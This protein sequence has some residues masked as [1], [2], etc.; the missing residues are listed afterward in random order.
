[1]VANVE[2]TEHNT[3]FNQIV[4]LLEASH[5]RVETTDGE[6][7]ILA[8]VN[9]RKRTVSESSIRR[10]LKLNNEE[11]I[12]TLSDNE[13]F[14]NLSLMGYNILPNQRRITRGTIQ[15]SQSK[16]PSPGADET[17]FSTRDVRYEE[18][19][20]TDTSLDAGQDRE[21]IAKTSA[22]PHEALPRVTSLSGGEGRPRLL[23]IM[24]GG[25]KDLL[26]RMLQTRGV[27]QEEDL[28]YRDKSADKGRN[29]TNEM[30]HVLGTLGAANILASGGLSVATPTTRVTRSLRGVVIVS[31]SLI[32]ANIPSI[33]KED[34]GKGKMTEP[35]Q[36]S[37]EKIARIHAEKELEMMIAK[38]DRSNKIIAKY[39]SEYEQAEAGLL[40]DEK[41]ELINELLIYQRH[42]AQIKK[43]QAQQNKPATKTERRNFY[44]SILRSN[45]GWKAKDFK[46]M[47]FEQIEE[48]L[49]P[50]WEKIQ[51]FVPMNSKL[52]SERLKRPRIQLDKE[53]FKK[54]KTT[55]A[56]GT[57]PTQEQQSEEPKELSEEE[58][59]KM[60]VLVPI[61]E[62]YIEALQ[63]TDKKAK[64]LWVELKRLYEPDFRDPLWAL[65]R[66]MQDLLSM[67]AL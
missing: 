34:K 45:A 17:A 52:E 41:V 14:E 42:L 65:Q 5:I 49:I 66:Y 1:M 44:M 62:L 16:V 27:D 20:P 2:K 22:V 67:D 30:S 11:G 38:L 26:R 15:I 7:K 9:G 31:S 21:N 47:T 10:H 35:K 61:E 24:R 37:K 32:Y 59:K 46:G 36:P 60:I 64:E 19:F 53:R 55:K 18:A 58:L 3:D 25:E 13:L 43:Y 29:S 28:L 12:S 8:K 23:R 57:K 54:L 56:S 51:D 63:V 33:S 39:L 6:T 50:L 40:H 48:K 4:D